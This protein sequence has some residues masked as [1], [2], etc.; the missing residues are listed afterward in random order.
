M[1]EMNIAV[2]I[3]THNRSIF[4]RERA[5]GSVKSQKRVPDFLVIID[6][7]DNPNDIQ[8]NQRTIEF[9]K[10]EMPLTRLMS[11]TTNGSQ[12][13]AYSWNM[14]AEKLLD[15]GTNPSDLF[16]AFLDDDDAWDE[17][18]LSECE[19]NATRTLCDMVSSFFYRIENS[20]L[21]YGESPSTLDAG[22]FLV[23]NPGVQGSNIF[24]RMDKFLEAGCFNENL[25]SC[26]DR[27][28]CIRLADMG[29][30][31]YQSLNKP[32]M[33]HYADSNRDRLSTPHSWAKNSGLEQF[34]LKY[35]KR[36][37]ASQQAS[38]LQRAN[39][40][41]GWSVPDHPTLHNAL[42]SNYEPKENPFELWIGVICSDYTI[43]SP[44]LEQ[45]SFLQ[46]EQYIRS[47][48]LVLLENTL[49]ASDH[50]C[51]QE[52]CQEQNIDV[53]F[54]DE[55]VQEKWLQNGALKDFK[56]VPGKMKTIA[57][58]RTLLQKYIG[59]RIPE[60]AVCWILDDDMQ[61][62]DKTLAALKMMPEVKRSGVDIL[63]GG[64][65][66]SS[67][68]PPING[69]RIQLVDIL[70]NLQWL[71]NLKPNET[72]ADYS[73]ENQLFREK[74]PDYYYDLS[75]KHK[76]HL[77]HP[78]WLTPSTP[79]ETSASA[80][81]RLLDDA[82]KIFFGN[83]LTRPLI[84]NEPINLMESLVDSVNRGGNTIVFNP[85]ALTDT[86]NIAFQI[87][88]IDVRRSDM[89]WSII[90]KYYRKMTIK[91]GPF[92]TWHAGKQTDS[93]VEMDVRKIRDEI[94]GSGFYAGLTDYLKNNASSTLSFSHDDIELIERGIKN[95]IVN[96]MK[97]LK[98]TF[99]RS[100]GISAC[101][102]NLPIYKTEIR[103]QQFV[104]IIDDWFNEKSFLEIERECTS[105]KS[106]DVQYFLSKICSKADNFKNTSLRSFY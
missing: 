74:Y 2:I 58:A 29:M 48:K 28:L 69:I 30:V 53:S 34:W 1:R 39:A 36:M 52:F 66:N 97:K 90:N 96:R 27:D 105:L 65:E 33:F 68:N 44:L 25:S 85:K 106:K 87:N 95:H 10:N 102:K 35:S 73:L 61:L 13:A 40:L 75:R 45:I 98:M 99:Y 23:G 81:N 38:F 79:T 91:A 14:A 21:I 76:G 55:S 84:A 60:N 37:T 64:F 80:L 47:L 22:Q 67:P 31:K 54:I 46:H 104:K 24:I 12:G 71:N 100:R 6:D 19:E 103:L 15:T 11:F 59:E 63:I 8:E 77:E 72:M 57:C 3:A 18:Y 83:P 89:M 86:P 50:N 51:I 16:I 94:V 4:F 43:I 62:T 17:N 20:N 88:G 41:F 42:K 82:W 92:S 78:Y 32:L 56:V 70:A 5:I 93:I 101:L 26:T 9:T 49:S 7:S